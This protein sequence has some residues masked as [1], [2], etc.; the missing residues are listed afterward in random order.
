MGRDEKIFPEPNTFKPERFEAGFRGAEKVS[1]YAYIPFSAGPRNCIGQKFAMLE[2]KTMLTN[3]L[4]HYQLEY[5]GN[6]EEQLEL[7]AELILRTK[8]PIM[9]KIKP[10]VF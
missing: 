7:I 5:V 4:R 8:D 1:P 10:R 9:F 3:V 6:K 2:I